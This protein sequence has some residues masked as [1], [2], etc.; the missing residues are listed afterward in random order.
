MN[1]DQIRQMSGLQQLD[2][3]EKYFGGR[4]L[5]SFSD[6][7]RAVFFPAAI[8]KGPEYVFQVSQHK[9]KNG[10]LTGGL[11]AAIVAKYNP[12]IAK[13][14]ARPDG[15]IDNAGFERYCAICYRRFA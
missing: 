7:Y 11:S 15:F 2:L 9:D 3:V 13:A 10:N 4:H 6:L 14:C 8:G 1:T 5:K 12:G